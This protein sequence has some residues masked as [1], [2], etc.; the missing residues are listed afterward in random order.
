[1]K[2]AGKLIIE[3]EDILDNGRGRL[4]MGCNL[5]VMYLTSMYLVILSSTEQRSEQNQKR[6]VSQTPF[7]VH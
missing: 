6:R 3:E 1:M 7:R 4:V 2:K 5:H